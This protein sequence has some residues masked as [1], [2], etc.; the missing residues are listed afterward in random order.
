[1]L[2]FP[3]AIAFS[4]KQNDLIH[5]AGKVLGQDGPLGNW[6]LEEVIQVSMRSD[7]WLKEFTTKLE[8]KDQI[9]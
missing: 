1:M 8:R 5:F 3:F 9:H 2:L 6:V 7:F 4:W